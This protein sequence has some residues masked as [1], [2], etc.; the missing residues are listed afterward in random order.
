[1]PDP[2]IARTIDAT[3]GLSEGGSVAGHAVLATYRSAAAGE[4]FA[5]CRD[6]LLLRQG[7]GWRYIA[8]DDLD[9][10]TFSKEVKSSVAGRRL[11]LVLCDGERVDLPVDGDRDGFMDIFPVH[12][13]LRRR[14]H[15]H[16]VFSRRA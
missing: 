15:Q 6:G 9:R 5:L 16:K 2:I 13:W 7:L 8:N 11:V 10:V 14:L 3:V 12:A 4:V 1:M